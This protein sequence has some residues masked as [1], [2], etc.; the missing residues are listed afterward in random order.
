MPNKIARKLSEKEKMDLFDALHYMN[1]QELKNICIDYELPIVSKKGNRIEYIMYYIKTGQILK[2]PAIPE[3]SKANP[4]KSYLLKPETLILKGS[5]KNDLKTRNFFKSLIGNYFHFT[6]F[7]VDWINERWLKGKPP[8]YSEFAKFWQKEYLYRK[9][10]KAN[11]K[12]EWAYLSFIQR[13][14][15]Q[16]PTASK[17]EITKQWE[18]VRSSRVKKAIA[19]LQK[20]AIK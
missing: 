4:R 6:A 2:M 20:M 18:K 17:K 3:V 10:C 16:H 8:T 5:F 11:P 12:R 9:K 7:G 15:A 19:L 13:Y 1:M 14:Q